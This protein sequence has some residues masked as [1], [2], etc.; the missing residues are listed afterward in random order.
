MA[1]NEHLPLADRDDDLIIEKER[2]EGNSNLAVNVSPLILEENL[3]FGGRGTGLEEG[4][5]DKGDLFNVVNDNLLGQEVGSGGPTNFIPS[6]VTVKGGASRRISCSEDLGRARQSNGVGQVKQG[7][8][9]SDGSRSVYNKLVGGP[10]LHVLDNPASVKK[11]QKNLNTSS[12]VLPSASLRKKQQLA[13][14]L[15]SRKPHSMSVDRVNS[16]EGEDVVS[17][18]VSSGK[19]VGR[20]TSLDGAGK[21]VESSIGPIGNSFSNNSITSSDIRNCNRLFLKNYEQEVASKVWSGALVLG[22]EETLNL[23]DS[24][25]VLEQGNGVVVDC[26]KEIQFNEKR[27]EEESIKRERLKSVHQ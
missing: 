18:E 9:Y 26:I 16:L 12:S 11:K 7:G 27:D 19:V 23:G 15:I 25:K 13:R 17:V 4:G 24:S 14:S 20:K 22:V 2:R 10:S 3:N 5:A 8:V 21:V 1:N 6:H